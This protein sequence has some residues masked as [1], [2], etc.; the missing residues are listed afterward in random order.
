VTLD[1]R[2]IDGATPATT[3]PCCPLLTSLEHRATMSPTLWS[4]GR[5]LSLHRQHYCTRTKSRREDCDTRRSVRRAFQRFKMARQETAHTCAG[6]GH[7]RR[8]NRGRVAIVSEC[9][10]GVAEATERREGTRQARRP[11]LLAATRT[12]GHAAD[13]VPAT[14]AA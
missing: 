7:K 5:S 8:R 11:K 2:G 9:R 14:L 3:T 6:T 4:L 10:V 1:D 13:S 12:R